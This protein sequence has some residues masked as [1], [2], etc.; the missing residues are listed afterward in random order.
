MAGM[1]GMPGM[2]GMEMGASS[3]GDTP[4]L[5]AQGRTAYER[6][7]WSKAIDAFKKV[8]AL[9]PDHPEA[10]TYMGL[11]LA[12]AGHA[13]GAL[14]AFERALSSNPDF[15]LALW[16]RGMLLYQ[17][18]QDYSG[19]RQTLE[20]LLTL[21]PPGDDRNEIQKTLTEIA[22]LSTGQIEGS[23]MAKLEMSQGRIRGTV[24]IDPRL[25]A[26]PDS[27]AILFIIARSGGSPAS[28]PLAVKRILRPVFPVSYVLGQ[29]NVM[30]PGVALDGKV[31]ISAR[32]DRD[33]N[34]ATRQPGD[35]AG[36]YKKN[37]VEVG[38]E[39]VD[40]IIDQIIRP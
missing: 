16:G 33:G 13:D 4:S 7:D 19:A 32:V 21:L 34:P 9:D 24:S 2:G 17:T 23:K 12:Q 15:P 40:I 38:S 8:L 18:K 20:K 39:K 25:K 1:P 29:E 3:P 35:L 10:H 37:P 11:I 5:L 30:V 31:N 6:Q 14:M 26:K 28:P 22:Q 27:N 36:E